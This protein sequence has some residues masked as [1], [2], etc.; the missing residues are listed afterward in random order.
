MPTYRITTPEGTFNVNSPVELTNEQAYQAAM[1]GATP[2]EPGL[3]DKF[4]QGAA[5]LATGAG[6]VGTML[7]APYDAAADLVQGRPQGTGNRERLEGV[8]GFGQEHGANDWT[9]TVNQAA[10]E[11][12]MTM[13]PMAGVPAAVKTAIPAAGKIAMPETAAKVLPKAAT[14]FGEASARQLVKSAPAIADVGVQAGME[15]AKSLARDGDWEKAKDAAGWG[16]GGALGGRVLAKGVGKLGRPASPTPLGEMLLEEGV[17]LTPGQAAGGLHAAAEG[18]LTNVS[19][20]FG[21]RRGVRGAQRA[22]MEGATEALEEAGLIAAN[23]G[24]HGLADVDVD[25]WIRDAANINQIDRS[26]LPF[27]TLAALLH[28]K[29]G[30]ASLLALHALYGTQPG[31]DFLLGKLPYQELLRQA[32]ELA[33]YAAQIG[34]HIAGESAATQ[35]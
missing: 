28:I 7:L 1:G 22:G 14:K 15:G 11:I 35:E 2:K 29:S 25:K 9:S 10:P 16:A 13:G 32:P 17:P 24:A 23:P 3:M 20:I 6:K 8:T 21:V 30:G 12:A 26:T 27:T 18:H 34:R 5:D 33:P 4:K 31:R 19:R